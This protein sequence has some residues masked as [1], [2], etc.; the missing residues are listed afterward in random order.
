ME[1]AL[2]SKGLRTKGK[3]TKMIPN[4]EN[5]GKVSEEGL[6]ELFAERE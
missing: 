3:K 2:E 6:P 5:A 4:S 1:G